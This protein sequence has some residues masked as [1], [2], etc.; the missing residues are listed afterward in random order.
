MSEI[1]AGSMRYQPSDEGLG[2]MFIEVAKGLSP[3]PKQLLTG[4]SREVVAVQP[5]TA[6]VKE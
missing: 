2:K 4:N 1:V 3:N 6:L 5:E